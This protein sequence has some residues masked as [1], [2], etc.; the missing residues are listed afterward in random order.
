MY[1]LHDK[2]HTE[3]KQ[4]LDLGFTANKAFEGSELAGTRYTANIRE[5][6]VYVGIL[7]DDLYNAAV[8]IF[9]GD[10][11][12]YSDTMPIENTVMAIQGM[13]NS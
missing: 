6:T 2:T 13:V 4:L 1:R 7:D 12:L 10:T 5:Y 9:R 11:Q 8:T 3:M